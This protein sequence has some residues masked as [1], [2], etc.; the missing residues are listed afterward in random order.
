MCLTR[1]PAS[2][3][4]STDP[5]DV[6][7]WSSCAQSGL[8]VRSVR[9]DAVLFWSLKEDYTLDPGSLHGAC[10][11]TAGQK[12]T[13]VKWIRVAAFDGNFDHELPMPPLSR[14]TA[15]NGACVDEWDECALWATRG[16]CEKNADFMTSR[17]G[18]RDSKGPACPTSCG[19]SCEATHVDA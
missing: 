14:R 17:A 12:W 18:A 2:H 9:G 15:Q 16:W 4:E 8:P 3:Q 13:A 1:P 7:P 5:N 19:V 10:P 11:V 6:K